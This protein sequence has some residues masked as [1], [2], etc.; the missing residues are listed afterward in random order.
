M[1]RHVP[2]RGPRP[3]PWHHRLG[4]GAWGGAGGGIPRLQVA[5]VFLLLLRLL[6]LP[7]PPLPLLPLLLLLSLPLLPRLLLLPPPPLPPPPNRWSQ[8]RARVPTGP[9]LG[10]YPIVTL[11]Y[12]STTESDSRT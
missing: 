7:L 1:A 6:L 2:R 3:R 11:Q 5:R 9:R 10:L 4:P 12:S 8:W